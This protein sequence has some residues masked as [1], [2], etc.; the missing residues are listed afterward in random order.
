[1]PPAAAADAAQPRFSHGETVLILVGLMLGMFLAALDQT[2]VATALPRMAAD[3]HGVQRL[4]WVISAY[5]LA[6][7]AVTPIYGK[8]SDLY[9][10][11]LMLQIAIGIFLITSVLCGAAATID[12]LIAFRALQGL[13]GGGLIAMAHATIADVISPRER[14]RYQAYIASS[15][16]VASVVGPVLGG[17]FVDHLTWRWV[18]WINV[19][20]GL[21]ALAMA[22]HTLRRLVPRRVRHRIDYAGAILIVAAVL[23]LLFLTTLG[24]NELAWTSP[25][26]LALA[27]GT[28]LFLAAAIVQEWRASEPILPPRLFATKGYATASLVNLLTALV[29]LGGMVF[30]PLFLELVFTFHADQS[31][32]MLIP[33]TCA[34]TLAAIFA[35]RLVARTGRYKIFPILGVTLTGTGMLLLAMVTPATPVALLAGLIGLCGLGVGMVNPVM[36]VAIQNTVE[37]R[38]IGSATASVSFF[39]SMGGS[40]GVALFTAVLIARLDALVGPLPAGGLFGGEPGIRLVRAGSDAIALAPAAL[41]PLLVGAMA[42]AFHDIFRLAAGISLLTLLAVL[43]LKEE[44]LKTGA[45]PAPRERGEA[46]AADAAP[47]LAAPDLAATEL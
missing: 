45:G 1:M 12:Q 44:P 35:G 43:L 6:S 14:G 18:F 13:G 36:M 19:P 27:G 28:V 37:T 17:L 23:C 30:I 5:L 33:L 41:R 10:R 9:G 32:L 3:L 16:T 39:R 34:T 8:L 26:I 20:I 31:G 25:T 47:D 4:S 22:Q 38:D 42:G 29:M 46:P 21:A 15:F 40:F 2:I 11:K 7:T 24:G